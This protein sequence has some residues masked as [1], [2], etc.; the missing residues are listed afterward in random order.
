MLN[1]GI[2]LPLVHLDPN[3][4]ALRSDK[5]GPILEK[6]I[7]ASVLAHGIATSAC[8]PAL[9][10]T[11]TYELKTVINYQNGVQVMHG[12]I[13][14]LKEMSQYENEW[15]EA[16]GNSIVPT[17][18]IWGKLVKLQC[19]QLLNM[20]GLSISR[21]E[22]VHQLG[23][24][25]LMMQTIISKL[26]MPKKLQNLLDKLLIF[27]KTSPEFLHSHE[28]YCKDAPDVSDHHGAFRFYLWFV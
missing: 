21:T 11:E 17:T 23:F 20:Y 2:Y 28:S 19:L 12:T 14:Y 16:L 3:Q 13:Q 5:T 25:G 22:K 18:M 6:L 15:L 27:F 8:S 26:T 10:A 1:G 24:T 4:F 7:P 9:N